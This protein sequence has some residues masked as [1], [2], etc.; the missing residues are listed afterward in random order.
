MGYYNETVEAALKKQEKNL[1]KEKYQNVLM[2]FDNWT[3]HIRLSMIPKDK[4]EEYIKLK[5]ELMKNK[6]VKKKMNQLVEANG[7]TIVETGVISNPFI[8]SLNMKTFLA[9]DQSMTTNLVMNIIDTQGIGLSN[10]INVLSMVL[11]YGY[12]FVN[13]PFFI[14]IWFTGYNGT[15][16]MDVDSKSQL[17]MPS[18]VIP[19]YTQK[20][21][22]DDTEEM[23]N[24]LYYEVIATNVD[25][26]VSNNKATWTFSFSVC[27]SAVFIQKDSLILTDIP[28]ITI[29]KGEPYIPTLVTY[30]AQQLSERVCDKLGVSAYTKLYAPKGESAGS[31]QMSVFQNCINIKIYNPDG[32]LYFSTDKED[33]G[34]DG[35]DGKTPNIS[36]NSF[37]SF[38]QSYKEDFPV[39]FDGTST[40]L[41]CMQQLFSENKIGVD[42]S[43]KNTKVWNVE[44][45]NLN[46]VPRISIDNIFAGNYNGNTYYKTTVSV[47]LENR[48]EMCLLMND[49]DGL[50]KNTEKTQK[51]IASTA[52]FV[53]L[54]EWMTGCNE[55]KLLEYK[56]KMNK[57][58]YLNTG[59][60]AIQSAKDNIPSAANLRIL[61]NKKD[62]KLLKSKAQ[63]FDNTNPLKLSVK[64]N[65]LNE[66]WDYVVNKQLISSLSLM[67][68]SMKDDSVSSDDTR[69]ILPKSNTTSENK[70]RAKIGFENLITSGNAVTVDLSIIGDPMWLNVATTM[71][72]KDRAKWQTINILF[73]MNSYF[74]MN[75]YDIY[76]QDPLTIITL[77]YIVSQI[78]SDF[79]NGSFIQTIKGSVNTA[80]L[81]DKYQ[82]EEFAKSVNSEQSIG[83]GGGVSR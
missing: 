1:R 73:K 9:V 17:G 53:R 67:A 69:R 68:F 83:G 13:Q 74:Q 42:E 49:E 52:E 75:Q 80:F 82:A 65:T 22:K 78:I 81:I 8:D 28:P 16:I 54:Y 72:P 43:V 62:E 61:P 71:N 36:K 6:D 37:V 2:Q 45:K 32:T 3:Y 23:E 33:K 29:K 63:V 4:Y 66:C 12:N 51:E 77:P 11:G 30:M 64:F 50:F 7:V 26:D 70:T 55:N 31:S 56:T 18:K 57:L 58:W 15:N 59:L 48:P 5:A 46:I 40:L 21:I 35:F 19:I 76:E 41:N 20:A 14:T 44:N 24:K 27:N 79:H 39:K 10:K 60:S 47:Y 38:L 34:V 25:S